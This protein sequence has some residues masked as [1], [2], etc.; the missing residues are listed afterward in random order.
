[1]NEWIINIIENL[2]SAFVY[3]GHT[4]IYNTRKENGECNKYII[5]ISWI[6]WERLSTPP[7]EVVPVRVF[8]NH[9]HIMRILSNI[10]HCKSCFQTGRENTHAHTHTHKVCNSNEFRGEVNDLLTLYISPKWLRQLWNSRQIILLIWI[11]QG[12][13]LSSLSESLKLNF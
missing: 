2:R 3:E 5:L 1:M 4:N 6:S 10:C 13:L 12:V 7:T 11:L 8:E 9:C